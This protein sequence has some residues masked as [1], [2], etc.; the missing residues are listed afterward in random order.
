MYIVK[1]DMFGSSHIKNDFIK[2]YSS[3]KIIENYKKWKMQIF[4]YPKTF[5]MKLGSKGKIRNSYIFISCMKQQ[6]S[7]VLFEYFL[8]LHALLIFRLFGEKN[9]WSAQRVVLNILIIK[10]TSSNNT[11]SP[12]YTYTNLATHKDKLE[13]EYIYCTASTR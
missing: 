12:I 6:L 3:I 2:S 9:V 5:G 8:L 13:Y 7:S 10:T 1:T 11:C 4:W